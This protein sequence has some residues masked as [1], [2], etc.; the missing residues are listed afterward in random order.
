[1]GW[2]GNH[3]LPSTQAL[4]WKLKPAAA[5]SS[6][7]GVPILDLIYISFLFLIKS[8]TYTY[9]YLRPTFYVGKVRTVPIY[10]HLLD[11]WLPEPFFY[12]ILMELRI[13]NIPRGNFLGRGGRRGGVGKIER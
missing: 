11:S 12:I 5:A 2:D 3:S 7:S 1:M 9:P 4:Q 8:Y 6:N 13:R 10:I